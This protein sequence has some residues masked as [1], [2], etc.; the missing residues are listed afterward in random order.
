LRVHRINVSTHVVHYSPHEQTNFFNYFDDPCA[1]FEGWG[2][3][4]ENVRMRCEAGKFLFTVNKLTIA[5]G[6][7]PITPEQ[8]IF[9]FFD[10]SCRLE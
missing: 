5:G 6:N 2:V 8:Q 4:N 3:K 1:L 9:S 7:Y 10:S